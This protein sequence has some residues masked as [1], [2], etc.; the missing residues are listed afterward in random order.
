MCPAQSAFL[1]K[2]CEI[3]VVSPADYPNTV[4][5]ITY[6]EIR[7]ALGAGG[8]EIRRLF[9]RRGLVLTGIGL[10]IGLAGAAAT[11][12]FMESLLFGVTPLDPAAFVV[13]PLVLAIAATLATYL[14]ARRALA[15]D[16][17]ETMRAE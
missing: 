12:R 11:T 5:L 2:R 6:S 1:G 14:P 7:L 9:L 3:E 8:S 4:P 10:A 17:V 16:P 13:M 15:V